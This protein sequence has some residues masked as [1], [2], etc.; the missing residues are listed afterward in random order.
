MTDINIV[1]SS[2]PTSKVSILL[3]DKKK[4]RSEREEKEGNKRKCDEIIEIKYKNNSDLGV[5]QSVK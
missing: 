1:D 4:K 2:V 3:E 5:D